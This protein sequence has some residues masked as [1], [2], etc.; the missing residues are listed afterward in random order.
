MK[1]YSIP[2]GNL[3]LDGGAMFG[4]VPKSLWSKVYPVDQNNLC[5][6]AMRCLLV[7]TDDRLILIDNGIGDKQDDK[8]LRHYYLNGDD[9]L[10]GSIR[11]LGF[12]PE[13]I[14]D[15][16]ITH[17][18]F[19]HA[20]GGVQWNRD[21]SGFELT[22]PNARYWVSEAHWNSAMQPNPREKASYLQ[23]NLMPMLESGHLNFI[24]EEGLLFPGLE[25][26]LFHGHTEAQ[27]IPLIHHPK[28][29]LVFLADLIP[30]S[31]HLPL[32]WVIGYDV[33]PLDAMLEKD[34]FLKEALEK[35]YLLFFEHDLYVEA[36]NLK[37]TEKGIRK[38]ESFTLESFY[39]N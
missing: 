20:G 11:K 25:V 30:A 37:M 28:G 4:V 27:A 1:L 32:S 36:C 18:H 2:T 17:L 9:S 13:D 19:D 39:G 21:R 3:M 10:L 8:F 6:W 34:A 35:D 12:E 38:N 14:T 33:R 7:E 15:M 26:R 23:E 16:F 29:T 5:N 22:F 31:V 24:K